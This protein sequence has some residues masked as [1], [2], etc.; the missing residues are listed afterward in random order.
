MILCNWLSPGTKAAIFTKCYYFCTRLLCR[1][2]PYCV[3]ILVLSFAFLLLGSQSMSN[4]WPA[5]FTSDRACHKPIVPGTSN[6]CHVD[7]LLEWRNYYN[8]HVVS[9]I[10]FF[11]DM[12][13]T[14]DGVLII[15][16]LI[17]N[18]TK[19]SMLIKLN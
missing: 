11:K 18:E 1:C 4:T 15:H 3:F 14:Q 2:W 5:A 8:K 17:W 19:V 10:G 7:F 9:S 6:N 12:F 16:N 13:T